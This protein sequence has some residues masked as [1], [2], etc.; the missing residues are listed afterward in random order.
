M[1]VPIGDRLLAFWFRRGWRGFQ[2]LFRLHSR[3]AGRAA[4]RVRTRYGSVFDLPPHDYIPAHVLRE[5][6][7]ES[8]VFEAL[9]LRLGSGAVLWDIGGNFGLHAV[10][11]K[12]LFPSAT[13]VAFE[14][15]PAMAALIAHHA[16]LN[17]AEVAVAPLA[18]GAV[19]GSRQLH[20]VTAGNPGMTT[21]HPW[22]EA[23]Y[24]TV[25]PVECAR[26]DALVAAGRYPSPTVIKLDV[27]GGEAD[28]LLGLGTLLA[29]PA[30][31]AI[32]F[33]GGGGLADRPLDDPVAGPL[34]RA[35]FRLR[36]L[37]RREHTAHALENYAAER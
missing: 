15:N 35:G 14:P 31:R 30:L 12:L 2:P 8:E 22:V 13:V 32:V 29:A 16:R 17:R 7:Y 36:P 33:E 1:N 23:R 6:Y 5:G 34:L 37:S 25:I 3:F 4:L 10:T 20:V 11:A 24:D 26:G 28:V 21:L 27:E 9:R 19:S 18:L